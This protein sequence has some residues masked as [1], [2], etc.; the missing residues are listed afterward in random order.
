ML[1]RLVIALLRRS[2]CLLISWLLSPTAAILEVKWKSLS[3]PTLCD[4]MDYTVHGILQ[5][6]VLEWVAFPFF[7]GSSQP[8][9][10]TQVS[11]IASRW[12]TREAHDYWR[13]TLNLK[14]CFP[15]WQSLARGQLN[16]GEWE[17][18]LQAN[19]PRLAT[20]YGWTMPRP[21]SENIFLFHTLFL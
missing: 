18:A 5:V 16:A 17:N 4:P 7:R 11:C 8:R 21:D 6:R 3:C 1:S 14:E 20:G 12:A 2:M 10:W 19:R 9:D 15:K 13:C